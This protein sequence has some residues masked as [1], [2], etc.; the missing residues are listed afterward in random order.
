MVQLTTPKVSVFNEV[1]INI[2]AIAE[3]VTFNTE[4]TACT[5]TMPIKVSSS[6]IMLPIDLQGS[7]IMMPID[8]QGQIGELNIKCGDVTGNVNITIASAQKVGLFLQ[9]EWA[10]KE[11]TD[12]NFRGT[13]SDL[14][15]GLY[16]LASYPVTKGK[17]LIVNHIGGKSSGHNLADRDKPQMMSVS[18]YDETAEEY[19]F[20]AGGNG[21]IFASLPKPI[22]IPSE[23]YIWIM[24]WNWAGH[25][26]DV[27]VSA[28]GYEV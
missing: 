28:S 23:H 20:D 8:I 7:F 18:I 26:C 5:V 2:A 14:Q 12:K 6:E 3:A 22:R 27:T 17:T 13:T 11:Q 15:Y 9:P 1:A 16:T 19:L 25:N 21:G 24:G 4:I 10:A